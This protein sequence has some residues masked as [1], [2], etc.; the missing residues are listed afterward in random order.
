MC[1]APPARME[2]VGLVSAPK[3]RFAAGADW[4]A[5]RFQYGSTIEGSSPATH[6]IS[7]VSYHV[8]HIESFAQALQEVRVPLPLFPC[9]LIVPWLFFFLT[10][11]V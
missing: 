3:S 4:P 10:L 6:D 5:S 11:S 1:T 8:K 2:W 7:R 9:H